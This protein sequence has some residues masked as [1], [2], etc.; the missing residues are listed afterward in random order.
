MRYA[1]AKRD[2]ADCRFALR[3]LS[4]I[5]KLQGHIDREGDTSTSWGCDG[6]KKQDDEREAGGAKNLNC[7]S[8]P[9][10]CLDGGNEA[11][12]DAQRHHDC[13]NDPEHVAS[14]GAA[15]SDVADSDSAGTTG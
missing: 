15:C 9:G 10:D 6:K 5:E 3:C 7:R 12:H 1:R 8:R 2:V 13:P 14:P 11:K 4:A